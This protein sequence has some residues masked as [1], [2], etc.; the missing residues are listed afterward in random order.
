MRARSLPLASARNRPV[1]WR[2]LLRAADGPAR[3][4]VLMAV[5]MA[6]VRLFLN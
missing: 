5:V 1:D 6:F 2:R 3:L 4:I